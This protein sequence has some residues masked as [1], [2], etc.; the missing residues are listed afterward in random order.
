MLR[1][2]RLVSAA[3]L[4]AGRFD[5]AA[6]CIE[7]LAI[8]PQPTQ[9][10]QR[11]LLARWQAQQGWLLHGMP[12]GGGPWALSRCATSWASMPGRRECCASGLTQQALLNAELDVAQTFNREALCLARAQGSLLFEGLLG[13]RDHA[14]L[15]EMRGAPRR[16]DSL[17]ADTVALLSRRGRSTDAAIG[18]NC[19]RRGRLALCQDKMSW[20][21]VS[22]SPA[23]RTAC[24]CMLPRAVWLSRASADGRQPARLCPCV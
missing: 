15:L 21:P 17:L 16:A 23:W 1:R 19:L 24:S 10:L 12:Y 20:P 13:T 9:V 14:Q 4:F 3:L 6:A 22:S 8:Y 18:A 5:P 2:T 11:Q 7:Q